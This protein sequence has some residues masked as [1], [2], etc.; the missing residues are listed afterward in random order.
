MASEL[1]GAEQKPHDGDTQVTVLVLVNSG[2]SGNYF[3]DQLT[4]IVNPTVPCRIVG[5]GKILLDSTTKNIFQSFVTDDYENPYL[6]RVGILT[7]SGIESNYRLV[8]A[9]SCK[10]IASIVYTENRHLEGRG[11]T[12]QLCMG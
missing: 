3:D 4:P 6:V 7:V 10:V 12:I 11:I 1:P 8:K 5:A 9:K 2:A